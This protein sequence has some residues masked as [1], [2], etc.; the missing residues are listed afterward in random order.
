MGIREA[1]Y[2]LSKLPASE[3]VMRHEAET[4]I[5]QIEDYGFLVMINVWYDV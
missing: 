3:P 5:T 2:E 1:L 4:L